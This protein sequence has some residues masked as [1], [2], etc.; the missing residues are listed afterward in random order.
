[1]SN[2]KVPN[3]GKIAESLINS[4]HVIAGSE[5][6]KFFK[7]SFVNDGFTDTALQ[8]WKKTTNPM[9]GKRTLFGNGEKGHLRDSIR[10][11]SEVPGR[12]IVES[13]SD[14]AEIH[15]NGGTITVTK[16]MKAHFWKLYYEL[17]NQK[18][19]SVKSKAESKNKRNTTINAKAE[20][21]KRMALMKLGSKIKIP[22]R[23]FMGD[24]QTMMNIF[25]K[26]WTDKIDIRFK[27]HLN[28]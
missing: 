11:A 5:S 10:K 23:Q 1:M 15:N 27:Q 19:Y 17:S 26:L 9:A 2:N 8:P 20:F 13:D 21:C 22:K 7:Q 24:S 4:A 6:V 14:Y 18:T 16:A 25:D 28:K 12:I 3:F